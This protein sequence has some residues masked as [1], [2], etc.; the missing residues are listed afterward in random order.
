MV[1]KKTRMPGL[2]ILCTLVLFASSALAKVEVNKLCTPEKGKAI[3]VSQELGAN[4]NPG[5]KDKPLKNIDKAITQALPGD[6]ILVA[7]G[8]YSGT[9]GIGYLVSDK[10]LKLYGGFSKDFSERDVLKH[11]T[12]FQP[13]NASGSKARKPLLSFTKEIDGVVIDG[14]VFDMGERNSY[15]SQEG[16]PDGVE[17]GMLLLPPQK[18]AGQNPTVT[19]PRMSIASA[20]AGGDILIR[21]NVF[22]NGANFA[23]QAGIRSGT[24]KVINNVFVSNRMAAI[25]I[26]GTC[27]NKGGPKSLTLCGNVEIAYKYYPI[28]LEPFKGLPGHGLRHPGDD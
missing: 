26:Y 10:P 12:L 6:T 19:E 1:Y 24:F 9:F 8:V 28:F 7:E 25:E 18:E 17:T 22:V 5:T 13:D 3:F 2:I 16:K 4:N 27:P 23:I 21:N 11:P 20:A 14:F 15:S